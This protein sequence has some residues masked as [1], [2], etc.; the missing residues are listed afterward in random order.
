LGSSVQSAEGSKVVILAIRNPG[1]VRIGGGAE[2]ELV[3]VEA[4]RI[5]EGDAVFESLARVAADD[6]RETAVRIAKQ[7]IEDLIVG[8]LVVGR[9][10]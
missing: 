5:F 3:W 8:E 6:M 2:A 7:K 9:E 1:G 10:D 4:L